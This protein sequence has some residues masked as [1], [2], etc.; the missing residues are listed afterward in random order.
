MFI[1][2]HDG[3]PLT[4]M[5][6]PYVTYGLMALNIVMF[7]IT[8]SSS[9]Y[10][11]N[12]HLAIGLGAIPAALFGTSYL[13][14]S[15]SYIPLPLTLITSQF[16]HI[17]LIHLVGNMLFMWVLSDNVEDTLGHVGFLIF[18]MVCGIAG[19]ML[20]AVMN[21]DSTRPLIGASGALSGVAAAYLILYPHVKIWGLFIK[22]PLYLPVI[23]A[24]GFWVL[25]QMG[26]AF[27]S[28]QS[29]IGWFAHVGGLSAG[30]IWICAWLFWQGT[31]HKD[32]K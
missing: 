1:P 3:V 5:R 17:S 21:P 27:L 4:R 22:I 30:M 8:S 28:T 15:L 29:S 24:L 31:K 12:L 11:Q 13:P 2:L 26:N 16:L 20:H 7:L 23:W 6:I 25:F 9:A 10:L 32:A 14:E 19:A 18:Y